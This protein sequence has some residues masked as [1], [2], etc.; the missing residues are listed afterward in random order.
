[1]CNNKK[2]ILEGFDYSITYKAD[3]NTI[4]KITL[5]TNTSNT[6]TVTNADESTTVY[7]TSVGD[8][9]HKF[10]NPS[11]AY[12]TVSDDSKTITIISAAGATKLYSSTSSSSSSSSSSS[13]SEHD[14]NDYDNYNHYDRSHHASVYY[15]ANGYTARVI[16]TGNNKVII[17]TKV[18]GTTETYYSTDT[19]TTT[20][21]TIYSGPNSSTAKILTSANGR[22]SI[23][24][25]NSDGTTT[26]FTKHNDSTYSSSVTDNFLNSDYSDSLPDG[27]PGSQVPIN[28]A[29]MYILKTQIVPPVC[30]M[31]PTCPSTTNSGSNSN[32]NSNTTSSTTS[33]SNSNNSRFTGAESAENW[34]KSLYSSSN[35]GSN[36]NNSGSNTN[37][38]GSNTNS[39]NSNTNSGSNS[40]T[41]S[42]SNTTYDPNS[43]STTGADAIA[44]TNGRGDTTN[45]KT[46]STNIPIPVLSD[47]STFG[48]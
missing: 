26:V 34:L 22:T 38:S 2:S 42:S 3:D 20:A 8:T 10:Y 4:A 28:Q 12:A 47:F 14:S 40:N 29:D 11:G 9:T 13:T 35:S 32:T 18:N 44:S 15:A 37:S 25:L 7:Q 48:M 1:M 27:I 24:V 39:N 33:S 41:N 36:S 23:S 30:P 17:I 43:W 6:I 5:N 16:D 46:S 19:T 45:Y 31:C 21:N